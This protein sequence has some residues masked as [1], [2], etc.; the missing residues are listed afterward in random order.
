[1]IIGGWRGPGWQVFDAD[2]VLGRRVRH[3]VVAAIA[4]HGCPV[5][6]D[7]AAMAVGELVANAIVHGPPGGRVLVGYCLW[8][9]GARVIVCDAGG[10]ATP[11]LHQPGDGD[12]AGRGLR[13]V[14]ALTAQ[15]GSFRVN[16]AQVVWCDLGRPLRAAGS[17]AW[18]WLRLVLSLESLS[19][20][21]EPDTLAA[22]RPR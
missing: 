4:Q 15:W 1:M 2:P 5:D 12:E 3:W 6:A 13:M 17:D 16:R 8:R 18:A 9:E 11:R 7:D 22:A 10:Q 14:E 21:A 19:A 20:P